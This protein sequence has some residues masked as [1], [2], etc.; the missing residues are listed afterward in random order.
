MPSGTRWQC[1]GASVSTTWTSN[2]ASTCGS[3]ILLMPRSSLSPGLLETTAALIKM[4]S[5]TT[6]DDTWLWNL[7]C[8]HKSLCGTVHVFYQTLLVY[9]SVTCWRVKS[10]PKLYFNCFAGVGNHIA[11]FVRNKAFLRC[12]KT[13]FVNNS[14]E[15]DKHTRKFFSPLN[16]VFLTPKMLMVT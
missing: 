15:F 7:Q 12:R 4:V 1:N 14:W 9:S 11:V 16:N 6:W 8:S 13:F 10:A 5:V 3:Q 2:N